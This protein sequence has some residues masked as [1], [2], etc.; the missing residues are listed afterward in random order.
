MI[1]LS[2]LISESVSLYKK[3]AVSFLIYGVLIT[4]ISV[5][6][7]GITTGVTM[8]GFD[9]KNLRDM[10][11]LTSPI[12]YATLVLIYI[13]S[14][15]LVLIVTIALTRT[16]HK[17][18]TKQPVGTFLSE[19]GETKPLIIPSLVVSLF[20]AL[21]VIGGILLLI[22]PGIIFSI[23]YSFAAISVAIDNKSMREALPYSKSLVTGRWFEV[24]LYMAVPSL[25]FLLVEGI[26][27]MIIG[28]PSAVAKN[29]VPVTVIVDL[30]DLAITIL[31]A[32]LYTIPFVILYEELKKNPVAAVTPPQA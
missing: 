16:I 5:L 32:P 31:L 7:S 14:T 3:H 22:I 23:W 10:L 6:M 2:T 19:L 29:N 4:V 1:T 12:Y 24:L 17:I 30:L 21:I 11:N 18:Y 27:S 20:T 13:I 26:I 9:I 25:V 15:V 28:I 8:F